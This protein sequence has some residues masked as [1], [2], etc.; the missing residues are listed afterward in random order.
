M[1]IYAIL[2]LLLYVVILSCTDNSTT[3]PPTA[4]FE[5]YLQDSPADY[6]SVIVTIE[7]IAFRSTLYNFP[8]STSGWNMIYN[9]GESFNLVS[10]RNGQRELLLKREIP[11]GYIGSLKITFG[12]SRIVVDSVSHDL[13]FPSGYS[14]ISEGI[15][16]VSND[17]N[18]SALVDINLFS[19]ILYNTDSS[20]YYFSPEFIFI[21]IDST[22]GMFGYTNPSADI[23]LFSV[24]DDDTT[25]FTTSE[26]DSN[27]FGFFGLPEGTYN[28]YLFPHDTLYGNWEIIDLHVLP[29]NVIELGT[30]DLPGG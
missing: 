8:D 3:G 29:D 17:R 4:E 1:R 7:E 23:F 24:E 13:N 6:D 21:D 2:S 19:S 30:I 12:S 16:Q 22:G 20:E 18:V 9:N 27:Y 10:L 28:L 26:P 14:A 11:V 15:I 25:G 5:L